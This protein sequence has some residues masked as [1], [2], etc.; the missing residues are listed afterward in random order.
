MNKLVLFLSLTLLF[1]QTVTH[2]DAQKPKSNSIKTAELLE[3]QGNI[4]GAIALYENMIQRQPKNTQ[5]F[6][7]LKRIYKQ[8]QLYPQLQSLLEQHL[9]LFTK[10]IPSHIELGEIHYFQKDFQTAKD[11]WYQVERRFSNNTSAYIALLH[12]FSQNGLEEEMRSLAERGRMKFHDPSFLSME[13]ANYYSA[14]KNYQDALQEYLLFAN[15]NQKK[16]NIVI[17]RILR[18][19]DSQDSHSIIISSLM[20]HAEDDPSVSHLI[21]SSLYFKIGEYEKAYNEHSILGTESQKDITRWLSFANNLRLEYEFV[22]ALKA[23]RHILASPPFLLTTKAKGQALLGLGQSFE[24]QILPKYSRESLVNFYPENLFFK[25]DFI[26]AQLLPKDLLETTFHLYDSVLVTLPASSFSSTAHFR[27]GA[28][29][30]RITQ[31]YNGAEFS[32]RSALKHSRKLKFSQK[33][34][35]HL[36]DVY[37]TKGNI[38]AALEY[39]SSVPNDFE[40]LQMKEIQ[41]FFLMGRFDTTQ[42]SIKNLLNTI[43]PKNELFNDLMELQDLLQQHY[44]SGSIEDKSAFVKFVQ[45]EYQLTQNKYPEAIETY[46]SLRSEFSN[47]SIV[48]LSMLREALVRQLFQQTT[49]VLDLAE[50]LTKT[51]LADYGWTLKAEII[52]H[53]FKNPQLA[54]D[55]YQ[56]VLEEYPLSLL[57]EPVRYHIRNLMKESNS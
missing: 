48:P 54:M 20:Q 40:S 50:Q 6:Y 35:L 7:R 1:S 12:M 43:H 45:A 42:V 31:D 24:D 32:F 14:R 29:K 28:I 4:D 55:F 23:Y 22:L 36:V 16:L 21:L 41:S 17:D 46:R 9:V 52:E 25:N 51:E 26:Q 30:Y 13:L 2:S 56:I 10:D 37:L 53:S 3:R 18:L 57:A 44:F 38:P 39:I 8:K 27:M 33:V 5:A 47:T 11:I 34:H 49:H 15:K 19:S